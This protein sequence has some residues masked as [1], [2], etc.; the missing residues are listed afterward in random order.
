MSFN[1]I[2]TLK[3]GDFVHLQRLQRLN[4]SASR[5]ESLE[6][7]S[8]TPLQSL[9]SL[10]LSSNRLKTIDFDVFLPGLPELWWLYLDGYS[11]F[12]QQYEQST[13]WL[14]YWC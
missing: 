4:V 1:D 6:L 14:R 8:M 2:R 10:D 7:G 11:I 13:S 5:L 9:K 3:A 12:V